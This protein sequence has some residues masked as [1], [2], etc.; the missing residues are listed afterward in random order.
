MSPLQLG[1]LLRRLLPLIIFISA[2]SA[3][4]RHT[5]VTEN[6]NYVAVKNAVATQLSSHGD[7]VCGRAVCYNLLGSG[8]ENPRL[9]NH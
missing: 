1:R 8:T 6:E 5:N 3:E 4:P 9:A 2:E 7:T